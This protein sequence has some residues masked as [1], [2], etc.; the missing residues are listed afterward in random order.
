[1]KARLTHHAA[2]WLIALGLLAS[3]PAHAE[4]PAGLPALATSTLGQPATQA[5]TALP[6]LTWDRVG[7]P[8]QGVA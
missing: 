6:R 2:P 5:A 8:M 4:Q 3:A 7:A 1:M